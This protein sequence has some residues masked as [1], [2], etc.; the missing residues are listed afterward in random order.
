MKLDYDSV[1]TYR[2]GVKALRA[3]SPSKTGKSL[4][5]SRAVRAYSATWPLRSAGQPRDHGARPVGADPRRVPHGLRRPGAS[6][7][8]EGRAHASLGARRRRGSGGQAPAAPDR[9]D[10]RA[11][12]APRDVW[13]SLGGRNRA[14]EGVIVGVL[15]TRRLAEP[16]VLC[17]P[18]HLAPGRDVRAA[19]SA[20]ERTQRSATPFACNDKLIGAYAFTDTYMTFIGA[21]GRDLRQRDGR[22]LGARRRRPR[23]AHRVDGRR[24]A[25]RGVDLRDRPR[26]DQRHG[27]GGAR[28]RVPRLPRSGLLRVR[29][30]GGYRAGDR[31]RR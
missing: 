26:H 25:G 3:T 24:L 27:T 12:S 18:G 16:P 17:R 31:R 15:D 19:S 22:V 6:A 1:A 4:K 10:A 5:N 21:A 8:R 28:D 30:S 9:R 20:T 29:L 2:G 13:P 23:D 7:S 11:S 14:G